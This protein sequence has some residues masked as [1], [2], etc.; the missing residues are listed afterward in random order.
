MKHLHKILNNKMNL[1]ILIKLKMGLIHIFKK[2][3]D[4]VVLW[5]IVSVQKVFK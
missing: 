4:V 1:D 3:V 5:S 2:K